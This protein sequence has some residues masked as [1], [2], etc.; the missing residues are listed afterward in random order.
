MK[1][2]NPA[3]E[4]AKL[5]PTGPC[6]NPPPSPI[7]ELEEDLNFEG[8]GGKRNPPFGQ[9]VMP[10]SAEGETRKGRIGRATYVIRDTTSVT[11]IE[12]YLMRRVASAVV[13]RSAIPPTRLESRT[14]EEE[15]LALSFPAVFSRL[16]A[17]LY[18]YP[19]ESQAR[20]GAES[21]IRRAA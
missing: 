15:H 20:G 7:T 9:I 21:G 11:S 17:G 4:E 10:S 13:G 8:E 3:E 2:Q 16:G 12:A 19:K 14:G 6:V 18:A 1:D 5:F